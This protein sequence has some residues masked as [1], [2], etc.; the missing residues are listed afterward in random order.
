MTG[1]KEHVRQ[2]RHAGCYQVEVQLHHV[3]K[4]GLLYFISRS[5]QRVLVLPPPAGGRQDNPGIIICGI[6]FSRK[7]RRTWPLLASLRGGRDRLLATLFPPKMRNSW[8]VCFPKTGADLVQ[9]FEV[10]VNRYSGHPPFLGPGRGKGPT[11]E[12]TRRPVFNWVWSYVPAVVFFCL[13]NQPYPPLSFCAPAY[14]LP[15]YSLY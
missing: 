11:K 12:Q 2:E 7:V 13:I 6:Y 15:P 10:M 5:R 9:R 8:V 3:Q 1:A 4:F 14:A